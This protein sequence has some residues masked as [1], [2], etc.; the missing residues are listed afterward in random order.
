MAS[1]PKVLV[2]GENAF[3]FHR[4]DEREA[5][6]VT[7][8]SAVADVET[9]TR[10]DVFAD[11][12]GYDVVVDDVTDST[13]TDAQLDGLLEFVADGGGYVGVHAAADLTTTA[14]ENREEPVPELRGL[15]GG[16]F[17]T[18]PE[19]G[20][21]HVE[22]D[23]HPI[24]AGVDDFEVYDE[25]YQVDWNDDVAVHARMNHPDL[26][27]YPVLW[28]KPYGSGRVCYLSLGHTDDA[29]ESNGFRD[30]L[31]NA[32]EWTAAVGHES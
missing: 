3:Q 11:L 22:L 30:L 9:T 17:L 16:H 13:L 15:V 12:D 20:T 27:D 19:K 21:F 6:F 14:G 7:I 25:P 5:S 10:K 28:T 4:F 8:L 32:V 26:D 24:T 18:H 31:R 2:V 23:D 29:F 1:I